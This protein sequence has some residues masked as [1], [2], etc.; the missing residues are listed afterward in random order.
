MKSMYIPRAKKNTNVI[1]IKVDILSVP[2]M[3]RKYSRL[4]NKAQRFEDRRFKRPKHKNNYME[5]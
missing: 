3:D 2:S 1:Q 5:D 4:R